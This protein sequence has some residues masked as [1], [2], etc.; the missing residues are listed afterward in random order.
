MSP[1]ARQPQS[2]MWVYRGGPPGRAVIGSNTR[3][4]AAARS[5]AFLFPAGVPPGLRSAQRALPLSDGSAAIAPWPSRWVSAGMP[6]VGRTCAEVRRG[7]E[8]R[9]HSAAHR[10]WPSSA[11]YAVERSWCVLAR[12]AQGR[13]RGAQSIVAK[14]KTW[15][16]AKVTQVCP[17][18]CSARPSAMPRLWRSSTRRRQSAGHNL[19]EN[20]IRPS[21]WTQ[22]AVQW[23]SRGAR[24][25][26]RSIPSSR[27]Q[28]Q[29]LTPRLLSCSRRR[30]YLPLSTPSCK[31]SNED[32]I[33]VAGSSPDVARRCRAGL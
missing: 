33:W 6:P 23:Q 25:A 4:P 3:R 1:G 28:G 30:A 10:W 9:E 22:G 18:G 31:P 16:D 8:A 24:P 29:R 26:P 17:R 13:A 7:R 5:P 11:L 27:R 20:A 21:W 12:R 15:L 32:S 19:A 2:F 14:I